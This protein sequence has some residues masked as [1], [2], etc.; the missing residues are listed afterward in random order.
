MCTSLISITWH[1]LLHKRINVLHSPTNIFSHSPFKSVNTSSTFLG[2][3]SLAFSFSN[4][5]TFSIGFMSRL[6]AGH[7]VTVTSSSERNVL[8]AFAVWDG[9]LSCINTVVWLIGVLKLGTCFFNMSLY[10]VALILPCS[11]IRGP[12]QAAE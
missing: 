6:W 7:S 5:Q 8:T 4:F 2:F 12:I 11:L 9:A 1:F 10:T 3:F